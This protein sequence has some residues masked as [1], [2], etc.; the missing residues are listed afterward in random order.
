MDTDRRCLAC[1]RVLDPSWARRNKKYCDESCRG[2]FWYYKKYRD[3]YQEKYQ[4]QKRIWER[5]DNGR[6]AGIPIRVWIKAFPEE[7]EP[8]WYVTKKR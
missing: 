5:S 8:T 1:G 7:W 6:R 2:S 3:R 4:I